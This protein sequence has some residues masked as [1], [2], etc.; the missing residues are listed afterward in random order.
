MQFLS[1]RFYRF[2]DFEIDTLKRQLLRSGQPVTLQPKAFDLLL[3]LVENCGRLLTK[4]DLLN[5]VWPDQIVEESNLT[6]HMSALRKAL[7][8]QRDQR[9]FVVTEPGRGYRF[10]ADVSEVDAESEEF[11][12]ESHT[13][14][15]I[16]IEEE[17][18]SRDEPH[19]APAETKIASLPAAT[20][21]GQL[22]ASADLSR[23]AIV[24][25]Q[26]QPASESRPAK[27]VAVSAF[28]GLALL[29]LV[30]GLY[31]F[32]NRKE[33][34]LPFKQFK[35]SRLTNNGK[36]LGAAIAPD[37]KYVAYVLPEAEGKSLWVQQV[38]TASNIRVLPPTKSEFW[39]V[40]FSPDG[41]YLYY[42]LFPGDNPD[43]YLYRVPSL[44]GMT[45]RI[46]NIIAPSFALSPDGRRIAYTTSY[47]ARGKSY[48]SVSN[49]DG[50][51]GREIV[52]RQQPSNFEV[53]GQVISWS[54]QGDILAAV[55]DN[56]A[57]DGHY[58]SIM[59]VGVND[60][61]ERAL[62]TDRWYNVSS[63]QWLKDGSGLFMVAGESPLLPTQV[64]FLSYPSGSRRKITNDLSEY[65]WLGLSSDGQTLV[66]VQS[67]SVNGFWVGKRE[68]RVND[69][70]EV[71]SE[72]GR[73][74]P[75]VWMPD[76]KIVF[77]S[78]AD[79]GSNLWLMEP[80]GGGRSQLT[81][82]AQVSHRGL[83]ASPDGKHVVFVSWR[84]GKQNLWRL[85]VKEG[86][87]TRLTSGDGEGYPNC[88]PDG[89]W[90][91]Y[92]NGLGVGKPTLWRVPLSGGAPEQLVQTFATKP[93]MSQ[94][95]KR[96]A[97]IYM[98]ADKWRIGII[99][100]DSGKKLQSLDLPATVIEHLIR[101][102]PDGD[103]LYF[104]STVG[105]VG[106]VWS[107]PLDGTP[108]QQ[109]TNFTSHLLGDFILSPDGQRIAFTRGMESR[110][111][112][113]LNNSR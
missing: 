48:L 7:G 84:G 108:P 5:R 71:V 83:C 87:L 37:G 105:D 69:F 98:D 60:G 56:Y 82:D 66:S 99:T 25:P 73:L 22:A 12:I 18:D 76:G 2:D 40:T 10:V 110:D 101:W 3:A 41:A 29:S 80:D 16:V 81:S 109:L 90:V 92:Q 42:N 38:G 94:D 4:D 6:V 9:R 59:G 11:S 28:V 30:F 95:G 15:R 91:V 74:S 23:Y 35:V 14:S 67:N 17:I 47:S 78:Q 46:P 79:G 32:L 31:K 61:A 75:S 39:G 97:Y 8:E 34:D 19:R 113:I 55:V 102:A 68:E 58:S 27:V 96:I 63:L 21:A 53:L 54:P 52:E 72:V 77:R 93:A 13:L 70:R 112:V 65:G 86:N 20:L 43:L 49:A 64:W 103:A 106:N 1:H 85:D 104:I 57:P 100:A 45:Q 24:S 44:G 89:R 50:S 26:T 107:L 62:S 36:V 111:V 51:N 33:S 88:S